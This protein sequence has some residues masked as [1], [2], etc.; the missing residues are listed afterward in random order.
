VG[1]AEIRKGY[2]LIQ[3][4]EKLDRLENIFLAQGTGRKVQGKKI[5]NFKFYETLSL[6]PLHIAL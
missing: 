4:F 6:A 1:V 2:C 3:A 5:S